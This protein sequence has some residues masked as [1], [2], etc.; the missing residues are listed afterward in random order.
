VLAL[1]RRGAT[2]QVLAGA[3]AVR[4]L[5][6]GGGFDLVHSFLYRSHTA[7][8][9]ARLSAGRAVPLVSSERCLGDNRGRV[10]RL[11]NRLLARAS[12]RVLAVSRAVGERASRRDGVPPGRVV[13]VPNGIEAPSPDP[14]ARARLRRALG[15]GPGDTLL[16][17]LGRLHREK[18]PDVL[19]QAL[20]RL[21]QR[22]AAGWRCVFVGDGPE[23]EAL[24]AAGA[25]LGDRVLFAGSRGRVAPWLEACDLLV[26]PSREEG[27]PVAAIEAMMHGRPVIATRVGGTPEVVRHDE[28]GILLPPEDPAALD[29]ALTSLLGDA[30]RREA[31]GRRG[32]EVAHSAFTLAAMAGATLDEYRRLLNA[33]APAAAPAP[34]AAAGSR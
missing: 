18:G 10:A 21:H 3:F 6:R 28:T 23:R 32:L 30:A 14:R 27:M 16:L 4:R 11:V 25:P 31:M 26:L 8:R 2:A 17:A 24:R 19:V 33:D 13:V 34:A 15:L 12:D 7:C 5:V 1:G 9:L 29:D 22:G 20:M